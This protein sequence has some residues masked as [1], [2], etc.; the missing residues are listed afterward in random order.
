[1][2]PTS[3]ILLRF[4]YTRFFPFTLPPQFIPYTTY[5]EE[6]VTFST[7][8]SST[9]SSFCT[10]S[11]TILRFLVLRFTDSVGLVLHRLHYI[12]LIRSLHTCRCFTTFSS[13]TCP[14]LPSYYPVQFFTHGSSRSDLSPFTFHHMVIL[15]MVTYTP[16]FRFI[17]PPAFDLW[18]PVLPSITHTL[19][20]RRTVG[21]KSTFSAYL[22]FPAY[23]PFLVLLR[24]HYYHAT[25][26]RLDYSFSST[27]VHHAC[28]LHTTTRSCRFLPARTH[29]RL[30]LP[31]TQFFR[32]THTLGSH[33]RYTTDTYY[34]LLVWFSVLLP[35]DLLRFTTA[36]MPVRQN[37][38]F[39]GFGSFHR[40]LYR[41]AHS[42]F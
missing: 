24:L 23:V 41:Y 27:P 34:R 15:P 42:W 3:T 40:P 38:T 2:V 19:R 8:L 39:A 12:T 9:Y 1:M 16:Q 35:A 14:L 28:P 17:L 13:F 18:F 29:C 37:T 5:P 36:T 25:L 22:P 11:F 30:P 20:R 21:G 33:Y 31:F 32:L 6:K 10:G 26:L 7:F 4:T